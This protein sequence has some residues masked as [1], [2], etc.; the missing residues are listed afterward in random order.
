MEYMQCLEREYSAA[1]A[2]VKNSQ[3]GTK[4]AEARTQYAKSIDAYNAAVSAE[5]AVAGEF[6]VALRAYKAANK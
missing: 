3:D 1:E 2:T 4:K 6:N 5:E